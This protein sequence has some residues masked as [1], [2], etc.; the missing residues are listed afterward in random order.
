MGTDRMGRSA[1]DVTVD[2]R[3][4]FTLPVVVL[5]GTMVAAQV[6]MVV[7][8]D[9]TNDSVRKLTDQMAVVIVQQATQAEAY[10]A[11]RRDVDRL[12]DTR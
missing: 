9:Q 2:K 10:K 7:K 11:L 1:S 3:T 8:L 4:R 12:M 5:L 6:T